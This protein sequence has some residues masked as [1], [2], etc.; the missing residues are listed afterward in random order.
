MLTWHLHIEWTASTHSVDQFGS[1]AVKVTSES[2]DNFYHYVTAAWNSRWTDVISV[3]NTG[4][5]GNDFLPA[6]HE[7][8]DFISVLCII[9]ES[10]LFGDKELYPATSYRNYHQI[11][12]MLAFGSRAE[13][14]DVLFWSKI[15]VV[16]LSESK[17][18][19]G[20]ED[21]SLCEWKTI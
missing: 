8:R 16:K 7:W 18:S 5:T 2:I 14:I 6:R 9:R 10:I 12:P 19:L 21:S 20:K 15:H 11:F 13:S 4:S 1:K 17:S 3:W